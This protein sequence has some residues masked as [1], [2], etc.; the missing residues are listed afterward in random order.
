[1]VLAG[2]AEYRAKVERAG[3]GFRAV[4]PSFADL[5]DEL[6]MD[7]AQLT[8][9]VL[10]H[11]DF[12]LRKLIVPFVDRSYED[13]RDIVAGA[14]LVLT[15]SLAFAARLAAERQ[16][17][18]SIAVV[19]Q[20]MMF[21]SAYDPPEIPQARWLSR[22]LRRRG[23]RLTGRV[24]ALAKHALDSQLE[25]V[26]ALRRR[27]G[28]PPSRHHPLFEGRLSPPGAIALYSPLLGGAQPDYPEA[29][30]IVGFAWFDSDDGG[31]GALEPE[32]ERFLSEGERP[33]VFTLG[34]LIVHSP[35][36]FFRESV[37]AARRLGMRSVLLVGTDGMSE[38][39]GWSAVDVHVSAYAPHSRLFPRAA[40]NVHHGGVGTLAQ[41]LRAARPQLVVPFYADQWDNARRATDLGVARS[42]SPRRYAA[43][44]AARELGLLMR[45]DYERRAQ[46]AGVRLRCEDGAARGAD[47]A[48]DRL[49]RE[50]S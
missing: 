31:P 16:G 18:T 25:P 26:H 20:P 45:G 5:Q 7:R 50:S 19:L 15:S 35:G 32:L 21:L 37:A 27:I 47:A 33:L 11:G 9:A 29:T 4:R 24:L 10:A 34:S 2:A 8:R 38:Y 22:W 42:L 6:G 48:L 23:P 3:L 17:I 36:S 49:N 13:M 1:V 40:V 14:Q 39:G 43:G 41:A 44:A 30:N 28:L 12:L 46:D